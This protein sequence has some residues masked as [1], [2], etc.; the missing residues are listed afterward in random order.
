MSIE[1]YRDDHHVCIA[2]EN[3]VYGSGIHANQFL[4]VHNG[5][6]ALI[7]PGGDL[8]YSALSLELGKLIRIKDLDL[9]LAS[10]QDPDVI[11]SLEKWLMYTDCQIAISELWSRFLPHLIPGYNER[12]VKNRII[13]IPDRGMDITLGDSMIRALP[14]HFLH[15]EGNFSFYDPVSKILFS[16][17]IGASMAPGGCKEPVQDFAKHV[18]NM[19]GFHER[20]MNANRVC[21]FWVSMVRQLDLEMI[22]PQHGCPFAG[23]EVIGQFLDWLENLQCGV[24]LMTQKNY[25]LG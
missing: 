8:T 3:L 25:S 5:H 11:A 13:A 18:R 10:H 15:S 2:F 17:D 14:A 7:D 24:D 6:A 12:L 1:L 4:V 22:I 21:R 20:Y 19:Q 23:E 9:I 16:G